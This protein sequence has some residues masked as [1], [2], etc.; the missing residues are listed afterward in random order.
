MILL[1]TVFFVLMLLGM[2]VSFT[3]MISA[4]LYLLTH[5]IPLE[6]ALQTMA[7]SIGESFVIIAI[8]FFVLAGT[9]MN[10][11][12]IT[13]K[14]FNFADVC[15]GWIT[16]GLGHAN[17]LA[18][19]IFSGMSGTAVADAAGLGAIE[20]S[21]MKKAGYD[22]DFSLAITGASSII[23]PIIPPSVPAVVLGVAGSVSIGRLFVGGI[24]P[25]LMLG[26]AL[27]LM[28][29]LACKKRS[30]TTRSFPRPKEVLHSFC[31]SFFA[32]LTPVILIGG[33]MNGIFTPTEAAVIAVFYALV[34]SFATHSIT[35]K[36]IPGFLLDTCYNTVSITF[37]IASASIFAFV[38]TVEQVPAKVTNF[39]M[40]NVDNKV[41][42]ILLINLLLLV[43]G[44]FMET[45]AS[46]TILTPILLPVATAFGMDPVHFG[47]M[48]ILNLMLGLLTPPVGTVLYVL[49]GISDTS[50]ERIAKAITPYLLVM[51]AVLLIIAFVPATVLWLPNLLGM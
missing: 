18:S 36:E 30:Y 43:I 17:I 26:I 24:V 50:F 5:G 15:V 48:M 6:I 19:I 33:I 14:I 25:G 2:P 47:I 16:G 9:I 12:G 8:P 45:M 27:G 13:T 37:I 41:A 21:A 28:V 32:L 7:S 34:L 44:C 20:L 22:E 49:S 4:L 39:F 29:Y 51:G 31:N 1:L 46:L 10:S 23:G 3:M 11:S 40:G 35:I 42:A 38:L